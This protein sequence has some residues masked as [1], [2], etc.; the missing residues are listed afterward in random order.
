MAIII[1]M[2]TIFRLTWGHV[3]VCVILMAYWS[4]QAIRGEELKLLLNALKGKLRS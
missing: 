2:T 1:Y 3:V 4:S